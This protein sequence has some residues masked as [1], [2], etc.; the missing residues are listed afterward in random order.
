MN[1]NTIHW[2]T[3]FLS[4]FIFSQWHGKRRSELVFG[5]AP[6]SVPR[7]VALPEAERSARERE[8]QAHVQREESQRW[9]TRNGGDDLFGILRMFSRNCPPPSSPPHISNRR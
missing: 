7:G 9:Q 2:L 5:D 3:I 8:S 4:F 6:E 1:W